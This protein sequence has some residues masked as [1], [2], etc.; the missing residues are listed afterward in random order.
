MMYVLVIM[1]LAEIIFFYLLFDRNILSPS[2]IGTAMFFVSSLFAFFYQ[3]K[4][5]TTI[6][7]HTVFV[8]ITSLLALGAGECLVHLMNFK[9]NQFIK[10]N[11]S[12]ISPIKTSKML[13]AGISVLFILLLFNYYRE[14]VKIA[15]EAGYRGDGLLLQYA[16]TADL[17]K[18]GTFSKRNFLAR[19]SSVIVRSAAYVFSYIFLHNAIFFNKKN[20]SQLIPVLLFF[21]FMLLSTGRTQFIYLIASWIIFGTVFFMQTKAWNPKYTAKIVCFGIIGMLTF[22]LLF[23]ISG[24]FKS[25]RILENALDTIAFYAGLSIPSLDLYFENVP[26][27]PNQIFGEH[28]LT[29]IYSVLRHF[30]DAIPWLYTPWSDFATFHNVRGNV[31]TVIR[32]YHQDFGYIGLY[33]MMFFLGFF[34]SFLY[35]KFNRKQKNLGLLLYAMIFAPIVEMSIEERFFMTVV[36]SGTVYSFF[37]GSILFRLIVRYDHKVQRG[38]LNHIFC[39]R[40]RKNDRGGGYKCIAIYLYALKKQSCKNIVRASAQGRCAA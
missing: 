25:S 32:R 23:V 12:A 29:G 34:Y 35:L 3:N 13:I 9:R 30:S 28:T 33:M 1:L 17:N 4:W 26:Y 8:I 18:F 15:K 11:I 38:M 20:F 14:T 21:P 6:S 22:L 37:Y 19:Q 39:Y 16:R 5:Q 27:P 7:S 10:V 40:T 2:V 36:S 24:S 31:Y